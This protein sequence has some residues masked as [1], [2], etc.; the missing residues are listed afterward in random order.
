VLAAGQSPSGWVCSSFSSSLR[1]DPPSS[2]AALGRWL[3]LLLRGCLGD[4][5]GAPGSSPPTPRCRAPH[6]AGAIFKGSSATPRSAGSAP[7]R[8][9]LAPTPVSVE[10][11][12]PLV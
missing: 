10:P 6:R 11:A 9:R 12:G 3:L 2:V 5:D 1:A 8:F 7:P 4:G